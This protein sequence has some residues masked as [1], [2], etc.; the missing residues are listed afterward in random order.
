MAIHRPRFAHCSEAQFARLLDFYHVQWLYEPCTFPIAWDASGNV[1]EWF[2]PDFYLPQY[3]SFLEITV[4]SARLQSRK[5]RKIRL[6]RQAYPDLAIKLFTR[7]DVE[8][9]FSNRFSRAS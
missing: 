1:V 6:L 9:V 4:Q 3:D 2:A 7:H 8:R 5:N